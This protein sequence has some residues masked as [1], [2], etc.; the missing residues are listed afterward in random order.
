M[1]Q[2]LNEKMLVENIEDVVARIQTQSGHDDVDFDKVKE[3]ILNQPATEFYFDNKMQ[4]KSNDDEDS[5]YLWLDTGYVNEKGNAIFI[6]LLRQTGTDVDFKGYYVGDY[7]FLAK[8][9][10]SHNTRYTRIINDNRLRFKLKYEKKIEKREI[11]HIDTFGTV[12]AE[13]IEVKEPVTAFAEALMN[14]NI[15][16]G[17][18]EPVAIKSVQIERK[19]VVSS[20]CCSMTPVTEE[21]FEDLVFPSWRTIKGLDRYLKVIGRRISQLIAE[22]KEEYY[23]IN[24]TGSV[25]VN[26]GIMDHVGNDYHVM[27]RVNM[28]EKYKNLGGYEVEKL[29]RSKADY[30]ENGFD[31]A[32]AI[33][34]K[35]P[36]KFFEDDVKNFKPTMDDFDL[37][38]KDLYHIIEERRARF[39]ENIQQKTNLDIANKLRTELEMGIKMQMRDS[40]YA[41]LHYSAKHGYTSWLLP[42]HVEASF[43]EEP[44]LV[45]V[46]AKYG[47][48]YRVKTILPY[49]DD[50]KDRITALS[51]Y[52]RIW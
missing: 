27:Y 2:Y 20:N 32:Q 8:S 34:F 16:F 23:V 1:E 10:V 9:I 13:V 12:K 28:S 50:M 42:F 31:K 22:D 21:I 38:T 17:T 7:N 6:S 4:G 48:F 35:T 33:K 39:P 41:K 40:S 51:L 14:C 49:D 26:T 30:L 43:N 52:S 11:A 29:I 5:L 18:E 45:L 24:S 44:E 3:F 25:V 46:I 36:I 37:D 15:Q 47:E 19:P